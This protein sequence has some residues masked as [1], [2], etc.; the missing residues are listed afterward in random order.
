[1][2]DT[3]T[4]FTGFG[5]TTVFG[6]TI[7]LVLIQIGG[8]GYA[9]LVTMLL[10]TLRRHIGLKKRM[11]MAEA[12]STLNLQGLIPYVKT[13]VPWTLLFELLGATGLSLR[14]IQD[15]PFDQAIYHGAF[16]A[17]SAFNNAGFSS[18]S[19]NLIGYRGDLTV[20]VMVDILIILGGL[21]FFVLIDVSQFF[22]GER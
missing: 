18:F 14:F 20:N 11:M 15:Y 12:L 6:H 22:R 19:P 7:V 4:D 3:A 1:M 8:L 10:L 17:I 21:G 2:A 9:T 16:H 5:H 13:I